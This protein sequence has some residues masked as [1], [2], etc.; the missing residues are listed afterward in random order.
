MMAYPR[1]VAFA[2]AGGF[3]VSEEDGSANRVSW[4]DAAGVFVGWVGGLAGTIT[5]G[6][7]SGASVVTPGWCTGGQPTSRSSVDG[8]FYQPTSVAFDPAHGVLYVAN[9]GSQRVDRLDAAT[10]AF[11][12][13]AGLVRFT[14]SGGDA[15]CLDA[16]PGQLTPGWCVGG[17]A[18][19]RPVNGGFLPRDLALVD[20]TLYIAD[21]ELHRVLRL[22]THQP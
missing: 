2:P 21:S 15:G 14:P 7:C 5:G 3:F 12:G 18:L 4:Y 20:D 11:L 10:G 16:L 8:A 17:Q 13:W 22:A 1:D 6:P 19:A 9:L